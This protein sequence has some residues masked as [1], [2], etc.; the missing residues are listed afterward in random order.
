MKSEISYHFGHAP[1]FGLYDVV[2]K[3]LSIV[4]NTLDH[5]DPNK[6]PIDQIIEAVN[7]TTIFAHG[8]GGRAVN[9]IEEKGLSL[10][11]GNFKTVQEVIDNLN[12][13]EVQDKDCGHEY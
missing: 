11:T 7:P 2:T 10:K 1:F 5:V 8:I 3:E 4:K 9:I 13:L 12:N 6:S